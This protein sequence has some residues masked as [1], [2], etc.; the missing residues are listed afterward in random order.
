MATETLSKFEIEFAHSGFGIY[1]ET[2]S[3]NAG[4]SHTGHLYLDEYAHYTFQAEIWKA[5][6]AIIISNPR[7]RISMIST[8]NGDRDHF[9]EVWTG[10]SERWSRHYCDVYQAVREGFPLDIEEERLEWTSDD[11]AQEFECSFLGGQD[12]YFGAELMQQ[13]LRAITEHQPDSRFFGVDAA[14]KV[15]RSGIVMVDT[16][17]GVSHLDR[18]WVIEKTPYLTTPQ[19]IGQE[20]IIEN[21]MMAF[22]PQK[23]QI[24]MGS[25][26]SQLY[27][28]L[29]GGRFQN[30]IQG[31]HVRKPWKDRT[32]PKLKLALETGGAFVTERS[33]RVFVPSR[34]KQFFGDQTGQLKPFAITN[35]EMAREFERQCFVDSRQP[36][37]VNDFRRVHKKWVGPN[38]STFDTVRDNS[39]H[40][41]LFWGGL[42]GYDLAVGKRHRPYTP[43]RRQESQARQPEYLDYM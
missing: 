6:R 11:W 4:R 22:D 19:R 40:G 39:G 24:D 34:A 17:A 38:L 33:T 42:F 29:F 8:P 36:L 14:A 10:G 12:D 26:G 31:L 13:V 25:E 43:Q 1:S 9:H 30:R 41:D 23:L 35:P 7:L 27:G 32:V 37:L 28:L 20:R 21:L 3:E 18:S 5:A 16:V 15:D 2:Q